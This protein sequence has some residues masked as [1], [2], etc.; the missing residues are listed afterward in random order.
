MAN[1]VIDWAL[2]QS[3][4]VG[5]C[6]RR[7]V[8]SPDHAIDE[9]DFDKIRQNV[10]HDVGIGNQSDDFSLIDASHFG[11]STDTKRVALLRLGPVQNIDRL[12]PDQSLR[13][14]K[15]GITLVYGENGSGKSGYTRIAKRLCRSLSIDQLR[16]NVFSSVIKKTKRVEVRYQVGDDEIITVDWDPETDAPSILKQISVFDSHNA[17]LYVD[18]DN[19]IAYLPREIAVLEHHGSLCQRLTRSFEEEKKEL[20]KRLKLPFPVGYQPGTSAYK[21]LMSIRV[22]SSTLPTE[23]ELQQLA[24]LTDAEISEIVVLARELA[25]DPVVLA[26]VRLRIIKV[27]NRVEQVLDDLT[28]GLAHE[29]EERSEKARRNFQVASDAARITAETQFSEEPLLNV[30]GDSWRILFEAARQFATTQQDGAIEYLPASSGDLCVLCLEP[31]SSSG[32]ARIARFNSFVGSAVSRNLDETRDHLQGLLTSLDEIKVPDAG[33]VTEQLSSYSDLGAEQARFTSQ[34]LGALNQFE[35]RRL[36]LLGETTGAHPSVPDVTLIKSILSE[37]RVRLEAEAT[38]LQDSDTAAHSLNE[39]RARLAELK[40]RAKLSEDLALVIQRREDVATFRASVRCIKE[41]STRSVSTHISGLRKRLVTDELQKRILR[42]I[43]EFELTHIPFNI[44][45]ASANGQNLFSVGLNVAGKIKNNQVLSEGEQRALA[46]AC[47]LAEVRAVDVKFGIIVDDP[48]S[49]LD[50]LRVRKI[51]NRLVDEAAKG[52]QVVIFTHSLVFFNEVVSEAA[53]ANCLLIKSVIRRTEAAGFGVIVEDS[54]PW[55]A[56]VN[57]RVGSLQKRIG[58][59]K[60]I[61]EYETDEYRRVVKD[62]YSDLR[63]SWERAVEEVVLSK[64][65]V[66]FVPDVMTGRL[67]EVCITDEDYRTIHFAMKKA[68]ERSGHD[69]SAGRDIPLPL[70]P[71]LK[72]D[73]EE[74]EAFLRLYRQRKKIT[75]EQRAALESAPK[76]VLC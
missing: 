32:A 19:K 11:I 37:E 35:L 31:L 7:I 65:V 23:K 38:L 60:S 75:G 49:S 69:M 48:V 42:E 9:N 66:R 27:L 6:L 13:L 21:L 53:H 18:G 29:V 33:V 51:A 20:E 28:R 24:R 15:E 73:L 44:T 8:D 16:G 14:A 64:T 52:R 39:K 72:S 26:Q 47:F 57:S 12:A 58:E 59:L 45:A 68:S 17:K 74:L 40:D 36:S 67:K 30:G 70:P 1:E 56:D 2:S 41:V 55:V 10:R 25:A 54:E 43:E 4:W 5:D 3:P 76:G 22:D 71:E 34:I 46:L 62:F 61:A 63:E 50:H